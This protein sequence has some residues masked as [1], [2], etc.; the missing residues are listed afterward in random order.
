MIP[1]PQSE[2]IEVRPDERFDE[3]RLAAYLAGRLGGADG[4][5]LVRQFG[6][7]AA[8]LT[9]E[10]DYGDAVYVLRRPP[11]GPV[12][13]KSHDME[14]EHRVLSRLHEVYEPAP[15]SFLFC[16]DE[17][18]IGAPFLVMERRRGVVV[19]RRAPTAYAAIPDAPSP[20]T[21]HR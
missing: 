2:T 6:G 9:Y 18:I 17:G 5:L 20:G 16:S 14:R 21:G 4:E 8:N 11:L 10:L 13:P 1:E 15:R 7:G 3:E 12:A 19:R